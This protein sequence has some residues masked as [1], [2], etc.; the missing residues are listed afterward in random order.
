MAKKGV[1]SDRRWCEQV[2]SQ[3]YVKEATILHRSQ[4]QVFYVQLK[5]QKK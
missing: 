1:E 4:F 5:R 2:R 3:A